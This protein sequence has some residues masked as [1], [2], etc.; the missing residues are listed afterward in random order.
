MTTTHDHTQLIA[1]TR[2]ALGKEPDFTLWLNAKVTWT[3]GQP[4]AK[5]GLGRGS[6]DLIGILSPQGRLVALEGKTGGAVPSKEQK[7]FMNLVRRRGGFAAVF[8]T[9]EEARDALDRARR[10]GSQ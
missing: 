2:I 6:T 10:G 1:D 8:H 5:P 4:R 7:L 9:V 3:K